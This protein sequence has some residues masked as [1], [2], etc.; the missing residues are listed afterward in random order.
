MQFTAEKE[1]LPWWCSAWLRPME[2]R[3][4]RLTSPGNPRCLSAESHHSSATNRYWCCCSL[5]N[6]AIVAKTSFLCPQTREVRHCGCYQMV[7]SNQH[8]S[9]F[10]EEWSTVK[11]KMV[12]LQVDISYLPTPDWKKERVMSTMRLI[13]VIVLRYC[14]KQSQL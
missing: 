6:S 13:V 5:R 1:L 14:L 3:V 10:F 8:C 4:A 9:H 11:M 2:T 7:E 12:M